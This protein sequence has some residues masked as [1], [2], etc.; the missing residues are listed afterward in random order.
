MLEKGRLRKVDTFM[1]ILVCVIGAAIVLEAMSFPTGKA[2]SG[3]R[4]DWYVAPALVPYIIGGG[5]VAMGLALFI[6]GFKHTGAKG[7]ADA[8]KAMLGSLSRAG[9]MAPS[10]LRF[11]AVVGV[12]AV[13]VFLYIPRVDF[14]LSA[15]LFLIALMS[16]FAFDDDFLLKRLVLV[17]GGLGAL[18]FLYVIS[19]LDAMLSE[20]FYFAPDVVGGIV[21]A[22]Y[23]VIAG[24]F[25]GNARMSRFLKLVALSLVVPLVLVPVFKYLLYIPLPREGGIVAM[26]DYVRFDILDPLQE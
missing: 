25:S 19:G 8:V 17:F 13:S 7:T 26:M 14:V 12:I 4:N 21:L 2:L 24:G 15:A 10:S 3:V 16:M 1:G 5:L 11:I 18:F 9:N 20:G 22:A 6:V 23:L